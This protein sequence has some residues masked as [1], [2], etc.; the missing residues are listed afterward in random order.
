[1]TGKYFFNYFQYQEFVGCVCMLN[2]WFS[3][4][5]EICPDNYNYS[6]FKLKDKCRSEKWEL[7]LY[8]V[9]TIKVERAQVQ[10]LDS[11]DMP[12]VV[13]T[14]HGLQTCRKLRK[15]PQLQFMACRDECLGPCTQVHGQGFP[16]PS[17]REGVAG[18]PGACSQVF[19]HP[20]K[21]IVGTRL[22]RHAVL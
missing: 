16:P 9:M 19:C 3:S 20:I 10:F 18:T 15:S 12:V 8:G 7:Y 17:G 4:N 6:R 5:D 22:D 14:G 2:Y 13:T 21:C 1:M 11:G